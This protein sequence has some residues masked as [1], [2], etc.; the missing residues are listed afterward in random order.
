[1]GFVTAIMMNAV[2]CDTEANVKD[3]AVCGQIE[4]CTCNLTGV[5]QPGVINLHSL[6][7]SKHEPAFVTK[8]GHYNYSRSYNPCMFDLLQPCMH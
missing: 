1:M 2:N 7:S 3:F 6:V 8:V 4:R 5:E